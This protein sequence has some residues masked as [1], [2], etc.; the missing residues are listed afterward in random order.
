M[1]N[2]LPAFL[3]FSEKINALAAGQQFGNEPETLYE[4]LRYIM[5][6][7][8]KRIRPQLAAL[9]CYL[10][11]DEVEK[12]LLPAVGIEVF[13]NFTLMHD[14]IM[15]NAP[16]RRGKPTVHEIWGAN[17][18]L[19]SGDVMLVKAYELIMQVDDSILRSVLQAFNKTAA[20]VCEGQQLDMSFEQK[21]WVTTEE[22][23]HMI[24]LKTAVLLGFS[25]QMGAMIAQTTAENAHLLYEVGVNAG[26]GFQLQDDI[27]DVYG[28]AAKFGK[29]VGGD[30]IA[31]KKTFLLISALKKATGKTSENLQYWLTAT[32]FDKQEKVAA[33]K[34]IYNEL[35]VREEAEKVMN[36]YF[37]QSFQALEQLTAPAERKELLYNLLQNLIK[38][39]H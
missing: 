9:G 6:L 31:N 21:K 22:Y 5:S 37:E 4:P 14:D 3:T 32:E 26:V 28:D 36:N 13:H 7:G 17:T 38:R 11:T 18:A 23:L 1:S 16:L 39:E 35:N 2:T 34:A 20:E 24:R 29:Q 12:A 10:F 30:I 19:L 27:L 15:D 33:V 8:G 25:L